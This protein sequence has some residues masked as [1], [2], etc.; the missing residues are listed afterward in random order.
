MRRRRHW[1]GVTA[2]AALTIAGSSALA[3]PPVGLPAYRVV[4]DAIAQPLTTAPGDPARGR[5]I[6]ADRYLGMCL[7]CHRGPF[8]EEAQGTLAPDLAGAGARWSEGQL[9]LRIVDARRLNPATIMPSYYRID[10]LERV[11]PAWRNQPVLDAQQI[12][13]VIAFLRTLRD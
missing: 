4:G 3:E 2:A 11:G 5:R 12:E 13:D 6:I 8:P 9:R 7:L 10:G 1:R